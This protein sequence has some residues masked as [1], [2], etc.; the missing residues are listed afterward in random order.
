MTEEPLESG[1]RRRR[2]RQHALVS[3]DRWLVSYADFVTLLFALFVVL[4]AT[5]RHTHQALVQLSGAIH[6]GFA[7]ESAGSALWIRPEAKH[8]TSAV[9]AGTPDLDK[10]ARQLHAALRQPMDRGEVTLRRTPDGLVLSFQELGFFRSGEASLLPGPAQQIVAAGAILRPYGFPMRVEG[11]S[12]DQPIHTPAFR[13]N[14]E[15]SAARA[16]NVLLLLTDEAHCDPARF[17]MEA[18]GPYRPVA[19]NH[20][21]E[22]RRRNRRVDLVVVGTATSQAS[23]SLP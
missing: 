20:A 23:S 18:F 12:D 9:A 6:Q 7:T 1:K 10:I 11:H 3:H 5:S 15:L 21:L 19:D 2:S 16:M 4:Y 22:G 13:S 8:A 17:S 14:W